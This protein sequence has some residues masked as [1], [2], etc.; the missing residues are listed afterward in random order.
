MADEGI[1]SDPRFRPVALAVVLFVGLGGCSKSHIG[2]GGRV[3]IAD[4]RAGKLP[5]AVEVC[6]TGV[7]TYY[8]SMTG[9]LVVQDRTGAIKFDNVNATMPQSD[10]R[11]EV[12]GETRHS[13]SEMTLASPTV[14]V[15][16][17]GGPPVSKPTSP[18]DWSTGQVDWRWIEVEGVAH[19]VTIDRIGRMTLHM[20]VEGRPVRVKILGTEGHPF[21]GNLMGAKVRVSGVASRTSNY[22]GIEDLLLLS[23]EIRFLVEV[24]PQ[25]PVASIP[26][27]TVADAVKMAG[28]LADRRI[29]LRGSISAKGAGREQ[30]FRDATG[31]MR[32]VLEEWM[33][34]ETDDQEIIG[35]PVRAGPGAA[36]LEGPLSER[37]Y[38][39]A[40]RDAITSI[41]Q[42]HGLSAAEASR[43]LPVKLQAVVTYRNAV[44]RV[45]FVQ[46]PT[47]GTFLWYTG[48]V[49]AEF[50]SGDLVE[51]SGVTSPGEF[52]ANLNSGQVR[53]I[54]PGVMPKPGPANLDRL[55]T[56]RED[57]NWVQ[58]E[59][60]VAAVAGDT[61]DYTL[62]VVEG[63][64][65]FAAYVTGVGASPDGLM[66]ARVRLE[67]VCATLFNER[68]Q[69]IGIKLF[70][71]GAKYVA[72]LKPGVANAADIPETRIASLL[73]Y[74][75]DERHRVRVR[76][77]L[78]LVDPDG[79]AFLEDSTAGLRVQATLPGDI[80]P[81]DEV[82]AVG[83]PVPGV[84][85]AILENAVVRRLGRAAPLNPPDAS[86]E[87]ALTGAYDCQLVR[88]EARVVDHFSTLADQVLVVQ[89]GDLLFNAHL[90]YERQA[91]EWPNSGALLRL[92]GVTSVRVE[93]KVTQIVP[94]ALDLYM[95]SAGDITVLRD[96]PWLNARRALE[97]LAAMGALMLCC[98]V[99][100]L[101][102]RK[103]V[104]RQ[105]GIIRKQL[106][107]EGRLRE[108]AEAASRAKSE[109]VANMSHEI[110]TPMNGVMGMTE[111][112]LD[113]ETTVEQRDYLNMVRN[114]AEALLTV[115]NDIL[116]FS[117]I[118]AGKLDLDQVDFPLA[119]ALDQIMKTFSL[120]ASEK[121]LELACE[122]ASAI[123]DMVVGDPT[124]LRQIVNNLVGNALKFTEHGE[125]VVAVNLESRQEN[126]LLLHFT[127]RD[128]GIGIPAEQQQ[129]IFEA[130][131]Q[132]DGSTT[133]KY[134]GTGLGL[135]VSMRL[136]KMMGGNMWVESEAGHGSCFHF[137]ARM[138]VSHLARSV[139]LVCPHIPEGAQFLVVD[140]NETNRRILRDILGK[141]GVGVLVA[142][143][144]QAALA[145]MRER[146][147]SGQPVT[148]LVTDCNMPEMDGFWLA[149][150]V[151]ADP[152]L[153]GAAIM[154][155]T[156]AGTRGDGARCRDLGISAY[157]TKPVSQ[158]E[159]REAI[160]MLLD[161]NPAGVPSDG[162]ITRHVIHE[163]SAGASL[164]ILVAEDN[165]VNQKL[166]MRMLEKRGHRIT[167]ACNG[168]EAVAAQAMDQFDLVLMDIQMPGM[169]G[170]EATAAIRLS[171]RGTGRHQPIIAMTAHAM[172]GDDQRCL[173][174]GM[175]GYLAKP[176]RGEELYALLEGFQGSQMPAKPLAGRPEHDAKLEPA[177]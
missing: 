114:S 48:A 77:T 130:F 9:T 101:L 70:V 105:T 33:L 118:E 169:D 89:A 117:K 50:G 148:L 156:S 19:A 173:D 113:T 138:G 58:A 12:C 152:K 112:L 46:D 142:D 43:S 172:K 153:A 146:A 103:R 14:K 66:D 83:L 34:P 59:G 145:L 106:D 96:A 94:V 122:V 119:D 20:V 159:L 4:L 82:E 110:R 162:L 98:S 151:K 11:V 95:R 167:L 75:T 115:V 99:W 81:G 28:P 131:S 63:V 42:V 30:W 150:E 49:A 24:S 176:I 71:P 161:R 56:G 2:P 69:L 21:I 133:R 149:A 126:S 37:S 61:G 111:L 100:I 35:F 31:E 38:V 144:A 92:T 135:T 16:G 163:K 7:V 1:V 177:G 51:I 8:D 97:V 80:H 15:L 60:T 36:V 64:H 73:Q 26:V 125:I 127:V 170:F 158:A 3:N 68:H 65:T 79:T 86:T 143:S 88:M 13:Q 29:R 155:L 17:K 44:N 116:D 166:A 129:K 5:V 124:R 25:T 39:P 52:A 53:R 140:D 132:A 154:M 165:P 57:S 10:E 139:K 164:K 23:P 107:K 74:S 137:T 171:E 6:V 22:S 128:T 91:T 27:V 41:G 62:T 18:R 141:Y 160:F 85:S 174:A 120:R 134:G 54:G 32:L 109:F 40:T 123:P 45:A 55:Y 90:P 136:V 102:L 121:K 72:V 104:R 147:G 87:D 78:T 175:D 108:A 47:G 84:F 157:L 67:G 76:G 168:Q 93:D